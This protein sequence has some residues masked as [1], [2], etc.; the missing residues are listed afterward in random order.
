MKKFYLVCDFGDFRLLVPLLWVCAS[1]VPGV[2]GEHSTH[3]GY[4]QSNKEEETSILQSSSSTGPEREEYLLGPTCQ[5]FFCFSVVPLGVPQWRSI[6]LEKPSYVLLFDLKCYFGPEEMTQQLRGDWS[7]FLS[8][9]IGWFT[10]IP[11][12]GDLMSTLTSVGTSIY[13]HT[14]T[15]EH[16]RV[17]THNQTKTLKC[18]FFSCSTNK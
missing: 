12:L 4:L 11:T 1:A 5:M 10:I 7:S 16:T 3:L 17:H 15:R 14:R 2:C 13:M 18:Y 6:S 8:T 9:H